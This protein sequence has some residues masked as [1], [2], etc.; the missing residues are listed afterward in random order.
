MSPLP[1]ARCPLA[2]DR[3]KRVPTPLFPLVGARIGKVYFSARAINDVVHKKVR[4]A[5]S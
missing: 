4:A 1:A 5:F 2:A 3:V